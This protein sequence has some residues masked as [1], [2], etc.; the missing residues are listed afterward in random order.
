MNRFKIK[1]TDG[2][3]KLLLFDFPS[4]FEAKG[5]T[6]IKKKYQLTNCSEISKNI[7]QQPLYLLDYII[8]Y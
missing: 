8:C 3:F 1:Y 6:E 2:T 7:Y 4:C 5:K